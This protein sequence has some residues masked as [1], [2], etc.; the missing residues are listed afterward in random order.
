MHCRVLAPLV[1][2][3]DEEGRTHHCYEG[4]VVDIDADHAEYLLA[5]GMVEAEGTPSPVP[6]GLVDAR[7]DGGEEVETSD[8]GIDLPPR[9]PHVAA[10]AR[11]IDYAVATGMDRVEAES[12]TK[13]R[14]ISTLS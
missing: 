1:L 8:P 11:W 5:S 13:E 12:M 10:K 2:V 4:A 9:P 14:L 7:S 6:V 3:R